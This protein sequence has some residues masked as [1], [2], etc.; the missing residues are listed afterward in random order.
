MGFVV[1]QVRRQGAGTQDGFDIS[2][3]FLV[4]ISDITFSFPE[5]IAK[6]RD[7]NSELQITMDI[8]LDKEFKSY[9]NQQKIN[10]EIFDILEK[11][12]VQ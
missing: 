8:Q 4:D 2:I 11:I 9:Q 6:T 10:K 12:K 3:L 7:A 1:L 5:Y